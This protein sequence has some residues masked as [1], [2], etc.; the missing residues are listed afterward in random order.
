MKKNI[1]KKGFL[2]VLLIFVLCQNPSKAYIDPGASS[3]IIQI[4][5]APLFFIILFFSKIKLFLKK[6]IL[7]VFNR[8]K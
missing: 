3:L 2:F 5:C 8:E 1:L 7:K 6:L 4:I